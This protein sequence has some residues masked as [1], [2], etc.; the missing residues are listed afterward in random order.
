MKFLRK[1]RKWKT[2]QMKMN[3]EIQLTL[4]KFKKSLTETLE[5]K[6]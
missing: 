4:K 6:F 5:I 3:L 2:N 1:T